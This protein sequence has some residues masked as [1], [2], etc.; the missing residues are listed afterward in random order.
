MVTKLSQK[1]YGAIRLIEGSDFKQRAKKLESIGEL[2]FALI[3][4]WNQIEAT[5]K[6]IRYDYSIKDGWPDE[7]KFLGTT[8]TSADYEKRQYS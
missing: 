1:A 8:W 2:G 3:L 5:L 6:I 4:Y 7:L